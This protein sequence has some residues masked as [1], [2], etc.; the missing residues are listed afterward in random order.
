MRSALERNKAKAKG[1]WLAG[2]LTCALVFPASAQEKLTVEQ[3]QQRLEALERRVSG[4][5]DQAGR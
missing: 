4:T 5:P 3:L 1:A 2:A